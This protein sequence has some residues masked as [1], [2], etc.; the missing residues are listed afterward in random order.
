MVCVSKRSQRM[1]MISRRIFLAMASIAMGLLGG[2]LSAPLP[3]RAQTQISFY[4]PVAVGGAGDQDRRRHGG[5]F[6]EGQSRHQGEGDL[7]GRLSGYDHQD[8]HRAEGR[9]RATGRGRAFDRHVHAD[10]RGRHHSLRRS[11]EGRG[12]QELVLRAS[13]RPSCKTARR[14]ARPGASRSSARPWCSTGTRMPSRRRG[15]TP[16]RRPPPGTRCANSR[17]S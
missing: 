5:R 10:R 17:R 6:R 1:K 12:G 4:Y 15:S 16:R 13:I 14:A 3:A 7:F 2:L 9:R 11:G 8:P